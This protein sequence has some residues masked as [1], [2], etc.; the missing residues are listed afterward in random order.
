MT[1]LSLVRPL[2]E[3][4]TPVRQMAGTWRDSRIDPS[5]SI[6]PS[7]VTE[8]AADAQTAPRQPGGGCRDSRS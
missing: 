3:A 2:S 4:L 7:Q 5:V 8:S 6:G 1:A